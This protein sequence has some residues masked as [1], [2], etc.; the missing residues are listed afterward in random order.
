[1]VFIMNR[2]QHLNFYVTHCF[3]NLIENYFNYW[4]LIWKLNKFRFDIN[5]N[6]VDI[7][8]TITPSNYKISN[9]VDFFF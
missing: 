4:V 5:W 3:S 1:M 8:Q 2:I 7:R 6:S 9:E